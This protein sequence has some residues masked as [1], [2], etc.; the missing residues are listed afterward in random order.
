MPWKLRASPLVVVVVG[1]ALIPV[2]QGCGRSGLPD[3]SSPAVT[4]ES[5]EG[6]QALAEDQALRRQR[7]EQEA[8]ARK[9][10]RGLPSAG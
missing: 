7:Q 10:V 6:R 1:I 5:A 3:P 9:R 4:A 2:T 8:R